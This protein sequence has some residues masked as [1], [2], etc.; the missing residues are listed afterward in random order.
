MMAGLLVNTMIAT[1]EALIDIPVAAPDAE[2]EIIREAEKQL[3]LVVLAVP[4][5]R[6][7]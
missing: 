5:W 6:S 2:A 7:S 3:R 4:H 1:V